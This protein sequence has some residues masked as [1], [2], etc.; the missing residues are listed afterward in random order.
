MQLLSLEPS[1][2][3]QERRDNLN[4]FYIREDFNTVFIIVK[5]G[6][7][8]LLTDWQPTAFD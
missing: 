3:R 1:L 6:L 2:A 7:A 8:V 5:V 4:T